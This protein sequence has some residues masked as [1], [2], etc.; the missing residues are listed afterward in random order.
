MRTFRLSEWRGLP[1]AE[2]HKSLC[3]QALPSPTRAGGPANFG[4]Q[5]PDC[6]VS[7]HF[8]GRLEA[9]RG[10]GANFSLT[11]PDNTHGAA[12]MVARRDVTATWDGSY[13]GSTL[14]LLTRRA[15]VRSL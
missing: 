14:C 2:G 4:D 5:V 6:P 7:A 12:V 9:G 11:D 13:H 8:H 1:A 10:A 15:G 3:S